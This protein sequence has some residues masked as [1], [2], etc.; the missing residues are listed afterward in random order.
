MPMAAALPNTATPAHFVPPRDWP[1]ADA[2]AWFPDSSTSARRTK[3]CVLGSDRPC[4]IGIHAPTPSACTSGLRHSR[5]RLAPCGA[6]TLR[7]LSTA[8]ALPMPLEAA[9]RRSGS[10]AAVKV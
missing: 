5:L 3:A 1:S 6:R 10:L 2:S 8:P 9:Q 7:A 4:A